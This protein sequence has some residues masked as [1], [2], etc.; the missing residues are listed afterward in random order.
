MNMA[1][2]CSGGVVGSDWMRFC[3]D[4]R[5]S[6][7]S[8][9]RSQRDEAGVVYSRREDD[10][11]RTGCASLRHLSTCFARLEAVRKDDV[12]ERERSCACG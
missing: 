8:L 11:S 10:L 6:S 2:A 5:Q 3:E 7:G 12:V 9:L 1:G 4:L